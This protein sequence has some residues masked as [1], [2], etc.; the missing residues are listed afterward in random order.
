MALGRE[1]KVKHK[2]KKGWKGWKGW[3]ERRRDVDKRKDAGRRTLQTLRSSWPSGAFGAKPSDR[4]CGRFGRSLPRPPPAPALPPPVQ[5]PP[6][7]PPPPLPGAPVESAA[8]RLKGIDLSYFC[9]LA[10][11]GRQRRQFTHKDTCDFGS[12][13][14]MTHAAYCR[15]CLLGQPCSVD[16][17]FQ[18]WDMCPDYAARIPC[19]RLPRCLYLH[20]R[21][22]YDGA[23]LR[24]AA[25][26]SLYLPPL[27]ANEAPPVGLQEAQA[28]AW[29]EET[30]E[31]QA[32][33]QMV[34]R[35]SE[36][37]SGWAER[38]HVPSSSTAVGQDWGDSGIEDDTDDEHPDD[39]MSS[40][41]DAGPERPRA[42]SEQ[43]AELLPRR[44]FVDFH[45]E[46][47]WIAT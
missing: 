36:P 5:V 19:P 13:C 14:R 3:K 23:Q 34:E 17:D 27:E 42:A 9:G 4:P 10:D 43:R 31:T 2:D 28:D 20:I 18:H 25:P 40:G 38:N 24:P 12:R 8:T 39:D 15:D 32:D 44:H 47:P 30:E 41:P 1:R 45:E 46:R 16:C 11:L 26:P 7:P 33:F 22:G 6:P 37:T 21:M 29:T 35:P